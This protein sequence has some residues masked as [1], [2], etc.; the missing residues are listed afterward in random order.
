MSDKQF[1]KAVNSSTE[2]RYTTVFETESWKKLD[3]KLRARLR[4]DEPLTATE[5]KWIYRICLA[6]VV[7]RLR[8]RVGVA[9]NLKVAE[10]EQERVEKK[11]VIYV[12]NHKTQ[13]T[14]PAYLRLNDEIRFWFETYE[15]RV[16]PMW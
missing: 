6:L 14:G 5:R 7:D 2:A 1:E 13:I 3:E 12:R 8:Q 15:Q 16:R 11:D 9:K 10:V 4:N